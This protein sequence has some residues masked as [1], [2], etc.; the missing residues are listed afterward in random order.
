ML[1]LVDVRDYLGNVAQYARKCPTTTLRHAYMRAYREWAQQTL[2][3]RENI[4]GLCAANVRQYSLGTDPNV[5]ICG[6][7]A[8][9]GQQSPPFQP[10]YWPINVS[11]PANWDPNVSLTTVPYR[12]PWRFAYIPEGQFA[13]DPIPSQAFN[14]L[15]TLAVAPYEEAVNVPISPLVKYSSV[16]E[17]GALWYL[18]AMPEMP[19][20]DLTHSAAKQK[21]FYSGVSN[22]KAEVQRGFKTTGSTRAR[23]R[24]VIL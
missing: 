17:A 15:I 12:Q 23:P 13:L 2:W 10:Q 14:L 1:P 19:W 24:Q 16:F 22:G 7:V 18:L 8:M 11:D 21:E 20:T 6:I 9:Q 3:V 5:D 4:P